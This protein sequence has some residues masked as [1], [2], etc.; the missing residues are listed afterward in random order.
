MKARRTASLGPKGRLARAEFCRGEILLRRERRRRAR[1]RAVTLQGAASVL[2]R[3][4]RASQEVRRLRPA[5][6][7]ESAAGAMDHEAAQGG[8]VYDVREKNLG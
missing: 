3:P 5:S 1:Q 4:E 7:T 8:Q 2:L 6:E